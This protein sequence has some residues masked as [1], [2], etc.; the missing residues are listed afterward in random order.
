MYK[1]S[2]QFDDMSFTKLTKM[3]SL[4][5]KTTILYLSQVWCLFQIFLSENSAEDKYKELNKEPSGIGCVQKSGQCEVLQRE[6]CKSAWILWIN[7][8]THSE[9]STQLL[10]LN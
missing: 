7:Y 1:D 6:L 9:N 8:L 5:D 4:N 10:A 3:L 2:L